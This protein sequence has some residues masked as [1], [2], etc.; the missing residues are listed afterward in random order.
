MNFADARGLNDAIRTLALRHRAAAAGAL[1]PLGL[2]PGQETLIFVLASG[3]R[4]QAQLAEAS[5]CEAPTIT[6][7]VRRL[8]AGGLV[9]RGAGEDRRVVMVELTERGRLL[10]PRL[11]RAW[12]QLADQTVAGLTDVGYTQAHAQAVLADLA[13]GLAQ[14]DADQRQS[15]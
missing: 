4:T 13:R 15:P 11:R 2:H 1:A 6:M 10:L 3:P 5:G 12:R 9:R 8:E 14:R 7:S